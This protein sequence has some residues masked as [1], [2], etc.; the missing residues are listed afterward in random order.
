MRQENEQLRKLNGQIR[1]SGVKARRILLPWTPGVGMGWGEV[2]GV[3][4]CDEQDL[5]SVCKKRMRKKEAPQRF[6]PEELEEDVAVLGGRVSL[7]HRL[8]C[9]GREI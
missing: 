5:L 7:C 6:V 4:K 1:G 9:I 8:C 3:R 2:A